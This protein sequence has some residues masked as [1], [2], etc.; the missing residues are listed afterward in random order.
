MN[1]SLT[2]AR[3]WLVALITFSDSREARLALRAL[4]RREKLE[5]D[6][7]V[8]LQLVMRDNPFSMQADWANE[9]LVACGERAT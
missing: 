5:V 8:W 2:D 4:K 7:R 9:V 1:E 3:A 6:A